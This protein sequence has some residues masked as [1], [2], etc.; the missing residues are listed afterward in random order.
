MHA[1]FRMRRHSLGLF[2]DFIHTCIFVIYYKDTCVYKVPEKSQ[3][4]STHAKECM[5]AYTAANLSVKNV[6]K[7][8]FIGKKRFKKRFRPKKTFR[9]TLFYYCQ[10][11]VLYQNAFCNNFIFL[12]VSLKRF[13]DNFII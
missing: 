12:S 6:S 4:V 13:F 10:Y 9:T 1:F 3:T 7:N 11:L 5:H 2:W 8:V